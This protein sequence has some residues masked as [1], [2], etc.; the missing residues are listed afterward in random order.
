MIEHLKNLGVIVLCIGAIIAVVAVVTVVTVVTVAISLGHL[1]MAF[2]AILIPMGMI[3]V[4][5]GIGKFLRK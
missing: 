2:L 1:I 4:A 5:W 3:L